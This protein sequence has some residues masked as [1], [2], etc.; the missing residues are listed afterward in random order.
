MTR[1]ELNAA[2]FDVSAAGY[3]RLSRFVNLLLNE[4]C[5]LNLTSARD[6]EEIWGAHV[7]DSL[8]L[9]PAVSDRSA[10]RILD[11]GAG[12]GFPGLP[13]ACV[14]EPVSVTL[15]DSVGKKVDALRRMI[16]RL[17]LANVRAV[18][19]RAETLAHDPPL[20]E[21]FDGVCARAV[22]ELRVLLE[23]ATGFVRPGGFCWFFK[24]LAGLEEES[25][26]AIAAARACALEY[27]GA[28]SYRLAG[29]DADRVIVEYRKLEGLAADLP[30]PPGRAKKRPL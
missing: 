9:L 5:R 11:L 24:T 15:L 28:R 6:A 22:A 10:G 25:A 13:L 14:C 3:E 21:Q 7:C 8:A 17:S 27:V 16:D 12:G 26:A 23:Y 29:T 20:R 30:R 1:D 18:C 2:G 4:N 19:G